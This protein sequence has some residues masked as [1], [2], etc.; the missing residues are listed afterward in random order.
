MTRKPLVIKRVDR[1][2][3]G[4]HAQEMQQGSFPLVSSTPAQSQCVGVRQEHHKSRDDTNEAE[5]VI[6]S[7]SEV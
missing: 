1:H 3:A 7:M 5:V 6:A 4:R 2:G